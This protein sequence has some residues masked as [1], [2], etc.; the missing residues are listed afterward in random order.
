MLKLARPAPYAEQDQP[1]EERNYDEVALAEQA[2]AEDG[3][4]EG[5]LEEVENVTDDILETIMEDVE[6][7]F[8][9][10]MQ[11]DDLDDN[12]D[13]IDVLN[14]DLEI[15]QNTIDL[16]DRLD[17]IPP[18]ERGLANTLDTN[19]TTQTRSRRTLHI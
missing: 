18:D 13:D 7:P 10:I 6:D 5:I 14:I 17:G 12:D 15:S 9:T 8:N 1:I 11:E 19:M 2:L 3:R 16:I 4:N